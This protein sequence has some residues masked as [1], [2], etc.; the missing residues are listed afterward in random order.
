MNAFVQRRRRWHIQIARADGIPQRLIVGIVLRTDGTALEVTF[1]RE[2]PNQVYFT[3]DIPV[4][5]HAGILTV[6]IKPPY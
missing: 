6:H 3:I 4:E 2:T 5:E 1:D